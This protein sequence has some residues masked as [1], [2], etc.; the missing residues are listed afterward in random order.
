MKLK[1][2]GL[3]LAFV[4]AVHGAS[5][6]T[7]KPSSTLLPATQGVQA[8]QMATEVLS[9]YHYKAVPLDASLS[10]KILDQYLKALDPEKLYFVQADIDQFADAR[11]KLGVEMQNGDIGR[12]FDI[13]NLYVNRASERL[14]YAR[15]LL[16]NGFSFVSWPAKTTNPLSKF[17]TSVMTTASN[18]S[19]ASTVR[20]PSM[21]I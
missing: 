8:A 16:K 9:R 6:G 21:S 20:T 2:L 10:S 7:D 18:A 15:S 5:L 19:A 11:T 3:I 17:W 12:P 1:L 13:F 14:T 4:T